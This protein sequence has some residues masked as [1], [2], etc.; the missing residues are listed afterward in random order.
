LKK[1]KWINETNKQ[2][3]QKRKKGVDNNKIR[4]TKKQIE[5]QVSTKTE[6]NGSN[7]LTN[8][9]FKFVETGYVS[10]KSYKWIIVL[11]FYQSV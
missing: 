1:E 5:S 10:I 9:K 2:T 6:K 11:I 8:D 4:L 7:F 3:N